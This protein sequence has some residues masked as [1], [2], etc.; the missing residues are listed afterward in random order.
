MA[1]D[2]NLFPPAHRP[3]LLRAEQTQFPRHLTCNEL[4]PSNHLSS[5][6]LRLVQF[7]NVLLPPES[8]DWRY[9]VGQEEITASLDLLTQPRTWLAFAVTRALCSLKFV[10][11]PTSY[12]M[13]FSAKLLHSDAVPNLCCCVCPFH[14]RSRKFLPSRTQRSLCQSISEQLPFPLTTFPSL[15]TSLNFPGCVPHPIIQV[16][17]E[18]GKEYQ[19]RYWL[20]KNATNT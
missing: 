20:L 5:S 2:S 17:R 7:L 3:S 13:A 16:P 10:L 6:P 9:H 19:L 15:V 11:F 8:P 4:Q 1:G 18:D 14:R 12:S